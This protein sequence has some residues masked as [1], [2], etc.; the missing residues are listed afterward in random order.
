MLSISKA[1]TEDVNHQM[2]LLQEQMNKCDNMFDR[3][4]AEIETM[5]HFIDKYV[6]IRISKTIEEFLRATLPDS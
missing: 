2:N 4:R 6:P 5:E 3:S 1:S